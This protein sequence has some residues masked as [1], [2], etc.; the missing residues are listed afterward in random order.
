MFVFVD[1]QVMERE[2]D[3]IPDAPVATTQE[4]L[5]ELSKEYERARILKK[6]SEKPE[7]AELTLVLQ[8][9]V[10]RCVVEESNYSGCDEKKVQ[11]LR[12]ARI[13]AVDRRDFI[14]NLVE[15]AKFAPKPVFVKMQE[16]SANQT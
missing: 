13:C 12:L 15:G 1:G 11:K 5:T 16:V 7:F 9:E 8:E 10:A 4:E 14:K 3:Q 2:D 6:L